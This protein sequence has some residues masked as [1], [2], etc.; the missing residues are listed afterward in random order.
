MLFGICNPGL[1]GLR[2]CNP[3]AFMIVLVLAKGVLHFRK[4]L[5][6]ALLNTQYLDRSQTTITRCLVIFTNQ[7][8]AFA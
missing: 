1:L 7:R 5:Y 2:I 3:K 8:Q 4:S 6:L